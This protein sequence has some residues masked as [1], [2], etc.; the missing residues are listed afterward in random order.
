MTFVAIG[1]ISS[2]YRQPKTVLFVM[3]I[4]WCH[5]DGTRLVCPLLLSL[6][7]HESPD[8]PTTEKR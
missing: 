5:R 1:K 6:K 4:V 7:T 2:L 3:T 8:L